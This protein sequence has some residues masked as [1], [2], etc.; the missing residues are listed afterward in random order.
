MPRMDVYVVSGM[1]KR[2]KGFHKLFFNEMCQ[3]RGGVGRREKGETDEKGKMKLQLL[4]TYEK[5]NKEKKLFHYS[6]QKN[7]N[8]ISMNRKGVYSLLFDMQIDWKVEGESIVMLE[9]FSSRKK[10]KK[11]SRKRNFQTFFFFLFF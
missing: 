8:N 3:G 7:N 11:G 9:D 4:I 1:K 10:L 5:K 6:Y 2:K